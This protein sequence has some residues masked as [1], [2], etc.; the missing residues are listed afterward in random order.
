M[1]MDTPLKSPRALSAESLSSEDALSSVVVV[2]LLEEESSEEE[3]PHPA[4]RLPAIA[5]VNTA[6]T[7][8][9]FISDILL[10]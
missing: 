6:A 8:F 9:L 7:T 4:S 10:K 3:L 1:V 5:I 2:S